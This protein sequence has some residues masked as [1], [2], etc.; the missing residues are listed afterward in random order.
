MLTLTF[1]KPMQELQL[2][3]KQFKKFIQ[4][5]NNHYGGF[6]YLATFSRQ[7]NKNWHY[8]VI[9]NFSPSTQNTTVEE[10]WKYGITYITYFNTQSK[11]N[12]A[13]GYLVSNM[14]EAAGDIKGK[15][16]YLASDNLE[17]NIILTSYKA[18]HEKAFD[19][20]FQRVLENK[21]KILYET[22]NNLGIKCE[23]VNPETGELLTCT[24]PNRELSQLL[25][26][27]GYESW[28]SVFTHLSS[29]ARFD[30]R[31]SVLQT[32]VPKQKKSKKAKPKKLCDIYSS[33]DLEK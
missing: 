3:H 11:F 30:E 27:A 7:K 25:I 15:H 33:P 10:L 20:A 28:D 24:I 31:F 4:R 6:R 2:A 14:K 16:G 22:K 26:R 21:R 23:G 19:E 32:A 12:M 18:E 13:I 1:A 9:C 8:H 29:A 17:K 5:V